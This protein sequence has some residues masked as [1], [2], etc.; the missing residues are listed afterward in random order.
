M[1]EAAVN[2]LKIEQQGWKL[3]SPAIGEYL[4][5]IEVYLESYPPNEFSEATKNDF[6]GYINRGRKLLD[7]WQIICNSYKA[8]Y[9]R[10]GEQNIIQAEAN[11]QFLIQELATNLQ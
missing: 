8:K 7:K 2:P 10:E 5:Q 4:D 1:Q 6:L 3:L 11:V 9:Q